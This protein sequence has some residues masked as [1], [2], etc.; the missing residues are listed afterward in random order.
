LTYLFILYKYR[1]KMSMIKLCWK[2]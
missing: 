1:M 2:H